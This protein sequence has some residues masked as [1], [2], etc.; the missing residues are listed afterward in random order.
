MARVLH[1]LQDHGQ[2][3]SFARRYLIMRPADSRFLELGV[4]IFEAAGAIDEAIDCGER[5]RIRHPENAANLR[6]LAALYRSK[7]VDD[8]AR[9]LESEAALAAVND[10]QQAEPS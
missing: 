9:S 3:A 6:R 2:A 10:D 7:G 8:R 1:R 5:M 4:Q